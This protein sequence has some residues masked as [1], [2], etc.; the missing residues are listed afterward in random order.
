MNYC[1][2]GKIV[3]RHI[4]NIF[5]IKVMYLT[6]F[7]CILEL[8][9]VCEMSVFPDNKVNN[10]M[11]CRRIQGSDTCADGEKQWPMGI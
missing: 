5:D 10:Q 8:Q 11:A 2:L 9:C 3:W 4:E 7:F 1:S 6:E